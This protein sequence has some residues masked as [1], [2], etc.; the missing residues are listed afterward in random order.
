L[1]QSAEDIIRDGFEESSVRRAVRLVILMN[2]R[3]F[4]LL[5]F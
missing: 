4:R 1:N 2:I 5:P 3:G